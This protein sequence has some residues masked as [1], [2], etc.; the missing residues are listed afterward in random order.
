MIDFKESAVRQF[1]L[2]ITAFLALNTPLFA[3]RIEFPDNT[4]PAMP[5]GLIIVRQNGQTMWSLG[6]V[7][8]P[9]YVKYVRP[10]PDGNKDI[11]RFKLPS[12][13]HAP[14]TPPLPNSAPAA[15]QVQVPDPHALLY[16]EGELVRTSGMSRQLESPVLLPGKAYPVRIRVTYV[17]GDRF[18]IEDRVISLRAGESTS[19]AFDGT[20]GLSVP[21]PRE[22][23][24][25]KNGR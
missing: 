22:N 25:E 2:V 5:G 16:V 18:M 20:G 23:V 11:V 24:A 9:R 4:T 10:T 1:S 15:L 6:G 8:M 13:F 7:L 19:V 3:Q 17:S 14:E 12:V 21:L